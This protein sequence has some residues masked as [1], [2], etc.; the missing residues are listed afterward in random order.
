MFSKTFNSELSFIEV[1]FTDQ[2]SP[3][4]PT[5]DKISL[6]LVINRCVIYKCV[7]YH[8]LLKLFITQFS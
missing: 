2:N 1:L 4:I 6:N 7:R 8:P 5:E 3:P